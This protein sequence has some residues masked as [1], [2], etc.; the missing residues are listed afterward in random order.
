MH[1]ESDQLSKTDTAI[2]ELCGVCPT[3]VLP[4]G[5]ER[6]R[7]LPNRKNT[8]QQELQTLSPM[9]STTESILLTGAET[10]FE[11]L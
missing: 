7:T 1:S 3:V 5:G 9:N 4:A 2:G 11:E 6:L 8:S 10:A